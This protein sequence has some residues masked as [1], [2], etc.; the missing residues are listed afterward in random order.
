MFYLVHFFK[1]VFKSPSKGL[2]LLLFSFLLVFSLGQKKLLEDEFLKIIP[3]NK[4]GPSFYALISTNES[5]QNIARQMR[6]LPGVYKV[7]ILS[8]GQIKEEVK[9]ILGS[10]QITS[11]A[12]NLD[13]NYAGIKVIYIKGLNSRAQELVR[14]YLSHL[15]A[16]GNITLGAIKENSETFD[17][18]TIFISGIKNWGYSIYLAV[19]MIFWLLSILSIRLKIEQASYLLENYQRKTRV[20]LKMALTGLGLIFLISVGSTFLVGAPQLL[21]LVAAMT[22]FILGVL[23]HLRHLDW[24]NN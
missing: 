19:L 17:K 20:S 23:L 18:R 1:I 11:L 15:V 24:E 4:S 16:D 8:E 9:T 21:N 12:N 10:L 2:A 7:E 13:L 6:V 3:E 22:L 5:Y 14:D